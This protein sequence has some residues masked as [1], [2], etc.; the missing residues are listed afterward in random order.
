MAIR[1]GSR[2][3]ESILMKSFQ[4]KT[5]IGVIFKAWGAGEVFPY[6][7]I[8]GQN[9][10]TN[11]TTVSNMLTKSLMACCKCIDERLLSK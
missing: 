10:K 6:M 1:V 7:G 2:L 8:W 9:I 4:Q 11:I 3:F 5:K